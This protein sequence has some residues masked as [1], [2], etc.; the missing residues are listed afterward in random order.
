MPLQCACSRQNGTDDRDEFEAAASS[1]NNSVIM[2]GYT[3]GS[4]SRVKQNNGTLDPAAVKIDADG[5][6]VW[7]WQVRGLF[8]TRLDTDDTKL[9]PREDLTNIIFGGDE[10]RFELQMNNFRLHDAI[11]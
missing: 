9:V 2:A 10:S 3:K 7:R 6:E 5:T 8:E 1:D 4:W 11:G